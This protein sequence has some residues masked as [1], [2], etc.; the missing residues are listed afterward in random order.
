MALFMTLLNYRWAKV[1]LLQ[2]ILV[3]VL[4]EM[5]MA[6]LAPYQGNC[7]SLS[8]LQEYARKNSLG[9]WGSPDRNIKPKVDM[10][11]VYPY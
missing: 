9:I 11:Y 7:H 3:K 4:G 5:I 8:R 6:C 10:G 1:M 2:I